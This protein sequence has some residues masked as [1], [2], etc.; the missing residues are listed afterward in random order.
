PLRGAADSWRRI[1]ARAVERRR[2]RRIPVAGEERIEL[3]RD[4]SPVDEQP[5]IAALEEIVGLP[6]A[7]ADPA[8]RAVDHAVLGV[9]HPREGD[10]PRGR[11]W[12]G[13]DADLDPRIER[14]Q[15]GERL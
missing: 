3:Q 10:E 1:L 9:H 6:V 11:R 13:E 4:L 5:D 12:Y 7:G 8:A 2:V 14:A 15:R